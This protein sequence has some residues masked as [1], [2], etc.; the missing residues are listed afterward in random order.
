MSGGCA[1]GAEKE[2]RRR[3][4]GI[5]AASRLDTGYG[6]QEVESPFLHHLITPFSRGRGGI[7][8]G[9]ARSGPGGGGVTRGRCLDGDVQGT[10]G[11]LIEM[12]GNGND[13]F[14]NF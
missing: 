3:G 11:V 9:Y 1:F 13:Y 5:R 6:G 12:G 14:N 4:Y 7:G 10:K 8:A 2:E